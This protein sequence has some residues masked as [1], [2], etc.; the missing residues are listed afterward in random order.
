MPL[1]IGPLEKV[2]VLLQIVDLFTLHVINRFGSILIPSI[3]KFSI[4]EFS[5]MLKNDHIYFKYY[6]KNN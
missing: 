1:K 4:I 5:E 6:M 3:W 2:E